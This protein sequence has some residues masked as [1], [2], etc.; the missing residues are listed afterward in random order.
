[1]ELDFSEK[2]SSA[3]K[4][5]QGL[6]RLWNPNAAANW[7]LIFTPIF[8]AYIQMLNWRELGDFGRARR[9]KIWI[10][11]G[12][13]IA[14][15]SLGAEFSNISRDFLDRSFQI[16]MTIFLLLWYVFQG[17][18][19]VRYFAQ[20]L[21]KEYTRKSWGRPLLAGGFVWSVYLV[22]FYFIAR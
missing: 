9:C 6:L 21:G 18:V 13:L 7:S 22:S 17:R 19:Q 14:I 16:V 11:V 5:P 1:L 8:G 20:N 12:C 10:W 15:L 3:D 2:V 4:A